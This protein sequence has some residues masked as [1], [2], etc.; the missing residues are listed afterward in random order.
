MIIASPE[1]ILVIIVAGIGDALLTT[2]AIHALGKAFPE[3][4]IEVA[5]HAKRKHAL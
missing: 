5:D 1:N 2:P 4:R 3:A